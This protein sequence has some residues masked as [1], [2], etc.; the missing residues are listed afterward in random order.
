MMT[1][2]ARKLTELDCLRGVR[3]SV[4]TDFLVTDYEIPVKTSPF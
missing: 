3:D 2:C 1:L 4:S